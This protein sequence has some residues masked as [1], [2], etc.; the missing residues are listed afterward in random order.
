MSAEL[1]LTEIVVVVLLATIALVLLGLIIYKVLAARRQRSRMLVMEQGT[2][3]S[4]TAHEEREKQ[5]M[6]TKQSTANEL[7][8]LRTKASKSEKN[9]EEQHPSD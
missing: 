3:V 1:T 5:A 7:D 9:S 8:D 6:E 2:T 4:D